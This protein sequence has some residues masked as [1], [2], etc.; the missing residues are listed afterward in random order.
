MAKF[1]TPL[2]SGNMFDTD[3]EY[4]SLGSSRYEAMHSKMKMSAVRK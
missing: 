2:R 1:I 4:A 3:L